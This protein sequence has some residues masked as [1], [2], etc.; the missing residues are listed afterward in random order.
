MQLHTLRPAAGS[1]KKAKRLGRGEASGKGG[2]STR[3]TKGHQSRSGYKIKKGHE[4]GQM[5]LHRRVPKR[6]FHHPD[7]QVYKVVNLGQIDNWVKK[8][9]LK[10]ISPAALQ[11]AGIME[12][13][14][15]LKI[16]A[17]GHFTT[18]GLRFVAHAAS[19]QAKKVIEA[20]G[21]ELQLIS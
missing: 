9:G 12:A 15:R 2:T 21:S 10:E 17:K 18:Q 19:A 7:A 3:G 11:Q 1:V 8:Y 13:K 16:L 5:P 4:G 14:E 20:A 6:G